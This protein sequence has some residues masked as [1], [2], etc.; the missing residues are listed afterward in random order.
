[1]AFNLRYPSIVSHCP[2]TQLVISLVHPSAQLGVTYI[3]G[4]LVV[5]GLSTVEAPGEKGEPVKHWSSSK[6][7]MPSQSICTYVCINAYLFKPF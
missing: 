2:W 1:M 6:H 3:V 5:L 4:V 7:Q